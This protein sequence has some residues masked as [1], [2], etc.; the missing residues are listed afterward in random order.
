MGKCEVLVKEIRFVIEEELTQAYYL[1][2]AHGDC[3]V[4]VQ[5]WHHKTFPK[6]VSVLEILKNRVAMDDPVMWPLEAPESR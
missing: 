5:G 1:Y 2:E 3:P 6:S 4:Q